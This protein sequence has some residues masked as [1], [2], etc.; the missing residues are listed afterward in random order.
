MSREIEV[1]TTVGE[2]YS[3]TIPTSVREEASLS[4]GD[5]LRWRVDDAGTLSVERVEQYF[6]AFSELEPVDS[7][8]EHD[9]ST[10]GPAKSQRHLVLIGSGHYRR[11]HSFSDFPENLSE[12]EFL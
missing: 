8:V 3:V 7:S 12:Y 5:P 1:E 11:N 4:A 10:R 6:G 9:H 2:D